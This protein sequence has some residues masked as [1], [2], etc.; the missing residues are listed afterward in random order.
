M[1]CT[2]K[3]IRETS[4][5][6]RAAKSKSS[7]LEQRNLNR[8]PQTMRGARL[9]G[10]LRYMAP[11]QAQGEDFDRR[12]DIFAFGVV[13]WEMLTKPQAFPRHE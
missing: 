4:W 3:S 6:V 12:A 9:K 10:N 13:L 5:S 11:E 7:S 8:G 1:W 2:A